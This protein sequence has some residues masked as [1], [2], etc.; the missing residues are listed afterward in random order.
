MW[1]YWNWNDKTRVIKF[2]MGICLSMFRRLTFL[3]K[4]WSGRGLP[5]LPTPWQPIRFRSGRLPV[6]C[7]ERYCNTNGIDR[8]FESIREIAKPS[9]RFYGDSIGCSSLNA[10]EYYWRLYLSRFPPRKLSSWPWY[11]CSSRAE[12]ALPPIQP[13]A[14]GIF[15][16]VELVSWLSPMEKYHGR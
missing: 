12:N 4:S 8:P 11:T 14:T 16:G 5:L 7:Q 2:H 10:C 15:L 6:W 13:S 9:F 1:H 3:A